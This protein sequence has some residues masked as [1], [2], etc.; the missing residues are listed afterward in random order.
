MQMSL[1][2]IFRGKSRWMAH[3]D[4]SESPPVVFQSACQQAPVDFTSSG[5][6]YKPLSLPPVEGCTHSLLSN[7]NSHLWGQCLHLTLILC[8]NHRVDFQE[9]KY[10]LIP[11]SSSTHPRLPIALQIKPNS[12][13][14]ASQP[15]TAWPKASSK[16]QHSLR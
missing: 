14:T 9:T 8:E 7:L 4:P 5:F 6:S 2:E 12:L 13:S 1:A 3:W 10:K 15:F 16:H 11:F